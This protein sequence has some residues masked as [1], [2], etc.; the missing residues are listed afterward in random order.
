MLRCLN[1][2]HGKVRKHNLNMFEW[3]VLGFRFNIC[4]VPNG[5]EFWTIIQ[6]I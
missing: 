6:I 5:H 2:L 4:R 3:S 1:V